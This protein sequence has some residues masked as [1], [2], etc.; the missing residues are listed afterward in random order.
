MTLA[1]TAEGILVLEVIIGTLII[2]IYLFRSTTN[3]QIEEDVTKFT[4]FLDRV[5]EESLIR[6][7]QLD[8]RGDDRID[9]IK[10]NI[11]IISTTM[12]QSGSEQSRQDMLTVSQEYIK[13]IRAVEAIKARQINELK[14][15]EHK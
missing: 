9:S 3:K 10:H 14:Q 5:D 15:K 13:I 4:K 1:S 6:F 11:D 8:Q 12:K 7:T 2:L